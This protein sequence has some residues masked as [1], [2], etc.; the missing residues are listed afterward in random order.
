MAAAPTR[1]ARPPAQSGGGTHPSGAPAYNGGGADPSGAPAGPKWRRHLS[2]RRAGL[3]YDGGGA[4]PSKAPTLLNPLLPPRPVVVRHVLCGRTFVGVG[5]GL[6]SRERHAVRAS[7][8]ILAPRAAAFREG[9]PGPSVAEDGSPRGDRRLGRR[10]RRR[11]GRERRTRG[12]PRARGAARSPARGR[13]RRR[14]PVGGRR[15]AGRGGLA[16]S[17]AAAAEF[18]CGAQGLGRERAGLRACARCC[19]SADSDSYSRL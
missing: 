1:A 19:C 14:L 4:D 17:Y 6:L 7:R 10:L 3:L 8:S 11:G 16:A 2:E 15:R 13:G 9:V 18:V 12:A 5:D